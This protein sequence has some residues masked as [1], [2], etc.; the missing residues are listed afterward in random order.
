[1]TQLTQKHSGAYF[2]PD[3]IVQTLVRWAVRQPSDRLIDPSCGDG[4]FLAEH[5]NSV[6][7]EQ[8]SRSAQ[9]AIS[10]APSALVHEGDFFAWAANTHERFEC[11]AG[12]PPFI[13]YQTFKGP[14]R[15]T[16][17]RL[18]LSHG[19]KFSGLSSSWAPFLVATASLLQPGGR[20]AFVVPAEIGH[21]PYA[22]P[23]LEYLVAH[24]SIVHVIA[25]KE[26]LFP[27]LSE[28]C[29]LLYAD[30]FGA[31]TNTIRFNALSRFRPLATPPSNFISINV[32][33]WR[34]DWNGRLRPFV[35]PSRSRGIYRAIASHTGTRRFGDVAS[36]GIGYVTGANDFFHLRPSEAKQW[37]IPHQF[38]HPSVR[39]GRALP[40]KRLTAA[41]VDK[42]HKEDEQVLLLRLPKVSKVPA[43]VLK[44]L[45]S[46][47]GQQAREAYKCR[48]REPWYS[49]PDVQIPDFFMS[50]MSG[51]DVSLVSNEAGCS[52]TNSVH[53]V[54]VRDHAAV[55]Q[56]AQAWE[57]PFIK[58]SCELE[59]HPL[60]GGMLKLEPGEATRLVL[61]SQDVYADLRKTEIEDAVITMREWRHYGSTA[62]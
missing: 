12:N 15:D 35:L 39:N 23:L 52:C 16:A 13:R 19:A 22:T 26:K 40:Q 36:I 3:A 17:L 27:E 29:W 33:E 4:R 18:C 44:Y 57:T 25:F 30:G 61:P 45:D 10:R 49:V 32:S 28:D 54:R 51:K 6:G 56:I 8:D 14:V 47:A 31:A 37:R 58:L 24:F 50:Y 42:W 20:M 55:D 46:E 38:L 60:G 1:M 62:Q 41:T 11:A 5:D 7:I 48:V 34:K 9:K 43:T 59:G 21:A 53:G 2:T